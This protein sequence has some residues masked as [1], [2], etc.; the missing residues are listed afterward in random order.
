MDKREKAKIFVKTKFPAGK[1][2]QAAL[3]KAYALKTPCAL[4]EM[5]SRV[6]ERTLK[7]L[8]KGE[9]G[10]NDMIIDTLLRMGN[11]MEISPNMG[12]F[13]AFLEEARKSKEAIWGSKWRQD[14]QVRD[15]RVTADDFWQA[16]D[17][18]MKKEKNK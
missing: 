10:M 6:Y 9:E 13:R 11:E 1:E 16:F 12:T 14:V 15:D 5:P 17:E 4:K 8:E 7:I 3:A 2:R 18:H